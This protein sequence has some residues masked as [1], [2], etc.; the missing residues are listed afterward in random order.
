MR[1]VVDTTKDA[2]RIFPYRHKSVLSG[3]SSRDIA[4]CAGC[5]VKHERQHALS[6]SIIADHAQSF[7]GNRATRR[8]NL[9]RATARCERLGTLSSWGEGNAPGSTMRKRAIALAMSYGQRSDLRA[10]YYG[11]RPVKTVTASVGRGERSPA[12]DQYYYE[13]ARERIDRMTAGS[14]MA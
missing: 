3:V 2:R 7:S 9:Q 13:T 12:L 11:A 10:P 14:Y 1:D 6:G 5:E 4:T 8:Q